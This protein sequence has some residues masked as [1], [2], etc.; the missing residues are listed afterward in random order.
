MTRRLLPLALVLGLAAAACAKTP[1]AQIGFG[2][3]QAFVPQ[4]ADSEDDVGLY[5]SVAVDGRGVPYVTYFGFPQELAKGEVAI[6][7]PVGAPSVPSVLL[8]SVS[9][10]IWTRGA[11]AMQNAISNVNIAYGPA[12]VPDVKSMK[13]ENVN[14]TS[15]AI[16]PNG[17]ID[18]AWVSDTGVWFAHNMDGTSFT[19]EQVEKAK[20]TQR[21]PIGQPSVSVDGQGNAWV[22]YTRTTARGQEVVAATP[23]G[24]SWR[25]DVVATVPLKAGGAQPG[26]TAIATGSDGSPVVLY[27]AGDRVE[28]ALHDPENGWVQWDV[29]KAADGA[30]LSLTADADGVLHAAYYAGNSVHTATS[31]DGATWQPAAVAQVGAGQNTAGR[32]TGIA[33]AGDGTVYVTWYDPATDDV[34]LASGDGSSFTPVDTAGTSAGEL[35]S[36]AVGT[37]DEVYL[38]WYDETEQNLMLGAYGDVRGLEFAVQSPTATTGASPAASP[39]GGPTT[40]CTAAQNGSLSVAA[41]GLAFDTNCIQIPA[42][43]KVTIHFDNKDAGTPHNIAVYPSE[44]ELTNPLF[45]GEV[46]TGPK[47]TDYTVGP[48]DAGEYY[49]HCDVHPTMNGTFKVVAGGSGGGSGGSGGSGGGGSGGGGGTGGS[50]SVTTTVTASGLA[51][52]TDEID[53]AAGKPTTLTLDNKDAGVPHNI[54]IYPSE[55]QLTADAALFQGDIVTGPAT[56]TYQIPAL[57]AGTYYFHCDVH[58]TM[59]GTVVVG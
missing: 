52:D 46:I 30:G 11:V 36:I 7:R 6:P 56:A 33:V 51:F 53:L 15:I 47:T 8:T 3:G 40:E 48:L 27:A 2:A 10:G 55:S 31:K 34:H 41:S 54:A 45:Q 42:G 23:S 57:K 24:S 35:P 12:E 25:S 20:V 28:A 37:N 21:G 59:N 43:Q 1:E 4:V 16:D 39:T 18:V 22:A 19:A 50:V 29:E 9:D 14:G 32:S 44:Q 5:P 49:F 58:P 26:R 17:G 13:P 38:A